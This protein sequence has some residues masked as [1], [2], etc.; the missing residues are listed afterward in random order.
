MAEAFGITESAISKMLARGKEDAEVNIKKLL[1]M[2][3]IQA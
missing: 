3:S 1:K 2:S